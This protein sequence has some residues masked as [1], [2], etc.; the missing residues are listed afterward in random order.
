MSVALSMLSQIGVNELFERWPTLAALAHLKL[1]ELPTPVVH[2]PRISDK[3]DSNVWIKRDGLSAP[4]YGGNKVR[5]LEFSL[6]RAQKKGADTLI[7][8]GGVGSHHVFATSLY[9][10]EFG[11]DTHAVLLPQPYHAHVEEQLRADLAIGTH[12]YAAQHVSQMLREIVR[13]AARL[14]LQGKRPYVLPIGG[15]N[16]WGTLGYVNA[17][18][19][20]AAQID[21]RLCP[22][23]DAVFVACGSCATAAGLALGLAAGGVS[24][25]VVAVRVTGR[26]LANRLVLRRLIW[27]AQDILR[28]LEPRFPDVARRAFA[29]LTLDDSELGRG[30][31]LSSPS[32]EAA[33]ALAQREGGVTLDTTYTSKAFASLLRAAEGARRGQKLLFWNTLS[34]ASLAP[35]LAEAPE[36]PEEFVKL[37]TLEP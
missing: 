16:V 33:L 13:I 36:A 10:A 20:L 30:Y 34:N 35:F 28:G 2:L 4:R 1:T 14:K 24:T 3:V 26:M 37:L 31:G 7:T 32:S 19:E 5:K 18:L 15:S 25:S 23:P 9:G 6:G 12:L 27:N 8:A 21:A 17:G 22:D 11:F 29:S